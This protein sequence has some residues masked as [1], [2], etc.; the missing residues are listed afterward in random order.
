[1]LTPSNE[2]LKSAIDLYEQGGLPL[3]IDSTFPFNDSGIQK[4]FERLDTA[5]ARGKVVVDF[6]KQ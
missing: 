4:A 2:Y 1:M 3:E 6:D 5:R